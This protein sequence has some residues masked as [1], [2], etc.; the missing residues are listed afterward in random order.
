MVEISIDVAPMRRA[1]RL[2]G[3]AVEPRN[4]IP[5]L[6]YMKVDAFN[7]GMKIST[8]DLNM[9]ITVSVEAQ[10]TGAKKPF[11]VPYKAARSFFDAVPVDGMA[12]MKY[13]APDRLELACG[14][15]ELR[16]QLLCVAEDY[17][18]M[19]SQNLNGTSI[20]EPDLYRH[21]KSLR[22]CIEKEN[23]RYYLNGV[24]V[25]TH[26]E[27]GKMRTVSTD[28]H[29][30]G[31]Y[32]TDNVPPSGFTGIIPTPAVDVLLATLRPDGNA[33]VMF[34][35]NRETERP[36]LNVEIG[37]VRIKAKLIDGTFPDYTRDLPKLD[38]TACNRVNLTAGGILGPLRMAL[39]I[40]GERSIATKINLPAAKAELRTF[41]QDCAISFPVEITSDAG[42][43]DH[44]GF[45]G[46][47]L[48]DQ[49]RATP[50]F[51]I[52]FDHAGDPGL[53]RCED[54]NAQYVLMPMRV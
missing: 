48:M 5:V 11:L 21:L 8:T 12:T 46:R 18:H 20:S 36:F 38:Q 4:T 22:H 13:T 15:I 19:T 41:G 32:D 17:P 39:E 26:P 24:F 40:G 23:T 10:W 45:N 54:P 2:L 16:I 9:E 50:T 27:T 31:I 30:L 47:Y 28:G 25:T 1:L 51:Q 53:I 43:A 14:Q 6:G 37:D 7:S 35:G 52:M 34:E 29:R 42:S 33:L 44:I 3:R 49:A